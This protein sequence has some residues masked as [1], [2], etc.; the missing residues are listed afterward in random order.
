MIQENN[1]IKTD[2]VPLLVN[3][4]LK[5]EAMNIELSE[6]LNGLKRGLNAIVEDNNPG[7]REPAMPQ[8]EPVSIVDKFKQSNNNLK[9]QLYKANN[10]IEHLQRIV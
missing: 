10:L 1:Q 6:V 4:I 9:E 8:A 7:V 2:V 5:F 3:E